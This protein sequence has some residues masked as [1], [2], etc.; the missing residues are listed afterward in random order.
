MSTYTGVTNFQ[1]TVRFFGPPCTY[2]RYSYN[3]QKSNSGCELGSL[4]ELPWKQCVGVRCNWTLRSHVKL[5]MSMPDNRTHR[6]AN[7]HL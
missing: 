1:K 5:L 6:T 3:G 7:C 4:A 2:R